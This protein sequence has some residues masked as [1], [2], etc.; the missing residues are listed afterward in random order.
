MTSQYD[1]TSGSN[2]PFSHF[3]RCVVGGCNNTNRD[4]FKL[5][6]WPKDAKVARNWTK[7]VQNTRVWGKPTKWSVVCSAHFTDESYATT[8]MAR[9]CGYPATLKADADINSKTGQIS[10]Q[11][12]RADEARARTHTGSAPRNAPV[13]DR[14]S[15]HLGLMRV[16]C[17]R[18]SGPKDSGG[19]LVL[20]GVPAF[21]P[22]PWF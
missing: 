19:N 18:T 21:L 4:G 2:P 8:E 10:F 3:R 14:Q 12:K 15:A 22:S 11:E 13:A 7:F 9:M 1:V 5:H 16:S 17:I 20:Y 6:Q